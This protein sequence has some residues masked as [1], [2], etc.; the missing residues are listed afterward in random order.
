MKVLINS[1]RILFF[2]AVLSVLSTYY[3]S[4]RYLIENNS[5]GRH[6]LLIGEAFIILYSFPFW[7]GLIILT[8]IGYKYFTKQQIVMSFIPVTLIFSPM[9]IRFVSNAL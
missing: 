5:P 4:V 1:Y 3:W 9:L 8:F 6:E 7:L 2:L